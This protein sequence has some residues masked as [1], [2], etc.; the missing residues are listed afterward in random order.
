MRQVYLKELQCKPPADLGL[1]PSVPLF[2][3]HFPAWPLGSLGFTSEKEAARA[4]VEEA[5]EPP[6][7]VLLSWLSLSFI[8]TAPCFLSSFRDKLLQ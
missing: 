3:F 1:A 2:L 4:P 5:G 7:K 6:C 8:S